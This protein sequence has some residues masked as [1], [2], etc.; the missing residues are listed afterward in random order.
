MRIGLFLLAGLLLAGAAVAAQVPPGSYL[1]SCRQAHMEGGALI[2][3]CRR[4]NG[5]WERTALPEAGRC[6]GDIGNLDGILRCSR[7]GGPP[8][9]NRERERRAECLRVEHALAVT[10]GRF[11]HTPPSDERDRLE[12]RLHELERERARCP[13]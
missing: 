9:Y 5:R 4:V 3:V 13:G 2:A 7:P 12:R 10:R 6:V 8:A 11:A 1:R